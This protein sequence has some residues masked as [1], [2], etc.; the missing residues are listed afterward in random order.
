MWDL[1]WRLFCFC[2]F[3]CLFIST[4]SSTICWKDHLFSIELLLHLCQK[5][6]GYISMVY[7]WILYFVPLFYVSIPL[8]IPHS[9]DYCSYVIDLKLYRLIPPTLF[10][11]FKCFSYSCS[12]AFIYKFWNNLVYIYIKKSLYGIFIGIVLNICKF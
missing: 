1:G 3:L 12:S 8:Q 9:F 5:T 2:L 4:C 10:F 6:V 7:F 11:F